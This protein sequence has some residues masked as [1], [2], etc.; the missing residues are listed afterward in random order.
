M[1]ISKFDIKYETE[2]LESLEWNEE[3]LKQLLDYINSVVNDET[4]ISPNDIIV[5]VKN[6]YSDQTGEILKKIFLEISIMSN[7]HITKE[8]N[9]EN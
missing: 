6:N 3:K 7:L 1:K 9:Y 5:N 2:L 4:L 8:G